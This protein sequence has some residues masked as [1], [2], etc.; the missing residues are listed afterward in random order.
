MLPVAMS[1]IERR[2]WFPTRHE[3]VTAFLLQYG[4]TKAEQVARSRLCLRRPPAGPKQ[5][6]TA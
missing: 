5:D 6:E 3:L 1:H 2:A 4:A